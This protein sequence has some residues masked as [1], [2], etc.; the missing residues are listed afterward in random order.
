MVLN[1]VCSL[2]EVGVQMFMI[3]MLM[4]FEDIPK[5]IQRLKFGTSF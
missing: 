3:V 1:M 5:K 4:D 2:G